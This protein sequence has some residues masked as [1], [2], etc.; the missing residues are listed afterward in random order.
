MSF[1]LILQRNFGV[2][3]IDAR[4][5]AQRYSDIRDDRIAYVQFI[6]DV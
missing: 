4:L 5:V 3:D 2:K 6:T 1:A